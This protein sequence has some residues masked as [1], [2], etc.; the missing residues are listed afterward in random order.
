MT[1]TS[2]HTLT[3]NRFDVWLDQ[4][5]HPEAD[6]DGLVHHR[7]LVRTG[8]QLRA[9]LEATKLRLPAIKTAP[10]HATALWLWACCARL[11]L[12][13]APPLEFI[14]TELAVYRPVDGGDDTVDPTDRPTS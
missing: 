13:E 11:G 2:P 6:D 7:V 10:L 9:E 8:D 1:A 5:A 3:A 4:P 12:T 14:G